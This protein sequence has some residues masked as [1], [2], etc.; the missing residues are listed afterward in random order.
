MNPRHVKRPFGHYKEG[1]QPIHHTRSKAPRY[2]RREMHNADHEDAA[3][4]PSELRQRIDGDL[5]TLMAHA[6]LRARI[7]DVTAS[8][9]DQ[10]PAIQE[11]LS[12]QEQA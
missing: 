12:S 10:R 1:W 3:L 9:A 4:S 8:S 7:Y 5:A 2:R 6:A 11:L